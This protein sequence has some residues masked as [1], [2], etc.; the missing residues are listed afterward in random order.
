[1]QV[2]FSSIVQ[3]MFLDGLYAVIR[4]VT[5]KGYAPK[6]GV[7]VPRMMEKAH[8]LL[9]VQVR[10]ALRCRFFSLTPV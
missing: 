1:M 5:G 3:A 9:W 7:A 6:L 2:A 4:M 10:D 8:C